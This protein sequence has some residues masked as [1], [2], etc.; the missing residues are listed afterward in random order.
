[1][2]LG[3]TESCMNLPGSHN[4]AGYFASWQSHVFWVTGTHLD[5]E[6]P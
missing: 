4:I 6:S 3:E 5:Q 1:M 2:K